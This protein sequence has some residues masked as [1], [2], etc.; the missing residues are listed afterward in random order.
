MAE[1][2]TCPNCGTEMTREYYESQHKYQCKDEKQRDQEELEAV[3]GQLFP[4]VKQQISI[5][6][7]MTRLFADSMWIMGKET[8]IDFIIDSIMWTAK[9]VMPEDFSR[10]EFVNNLAFQLHLKRIL[11]KENIEYFKEYGY[12]YMKLPL[13]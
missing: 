12:T 3:A 9:R 13:V 10:R 1:Y 11:P 5:I 8:I 2:I 7:S 6:E 4:T